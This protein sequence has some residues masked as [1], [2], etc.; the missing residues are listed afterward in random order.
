MTIKIHSTNPHLLDI[1]N[2]NPN[3][4]NGLYL[5]PLKNG[6]IAGNAAGP[7]NYEIIFQDA[8]HSYI[9][10]QSDSLDFKSY[11][12]PLLVIHICNELFGHILKTRDEYNAKEIKW[13]N[14]T[15][16][17]ADNIECVITVPSFFINSSWVKKN[18]FLLSKYFE[19]VETTQ[20]L[21]SN[22]F[23]LRIKGNN[24]FEALNLLMIIAIFA[25]LTNKYEENIFIDDRL[26]DKFVRILTNINNVPYFVFYLFTL[27]CVKSPA[28]F[29]TVKPI[30]EA[31]LDNL[32]KASDFLPFKTDLVYGDLGFIRQQFILNEL[33]KNISVLDIG[34]GE[35]R[36][37]KKLMHK[38]FKAAY[39]AIDHDDDY[40]DM[41]QKLVKNPEN[42]NLSFFSSLDEFKPKQ[43][44]KLNILMT[45]VIEHNTPEEAEK[46]IKQALQLNFNK[47]IITTPNKDFNKFYEL[48]E[49]F[50]HDDHKFEYSYKEIKHF[51]HKLTKNLDVEVK[52]TGVG[53][54]VL[55]SQPTSL[56]IIQSLK[57]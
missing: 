36:Y 22:I 55:N 50:R 14:K 44:E 39:Y 46:L 56:I 25:Q 47:I 21:S 19:G 57:Q 4:D 7:N 51:I 12:I 11:C 33:D 32:Y 49:E 40:L 9:E 41:F 35:F 16:K 2:K 26:L 42:K 24:V 13:I 53:D 17:E 52:C 38:G 31:Y 29:K 8:K 23:S 6:I 10:T 18:N 5:C 34:C 20:S 48:E 1:L 54:K 15:F 45:E 27:R 30:F 3:T 28:Q 37:Y 43:D